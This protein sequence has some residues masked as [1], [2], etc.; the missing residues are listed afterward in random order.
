M[1]RGEQTVRP[2][3]VHRGATRLILKLERAAVLDYVS[4]ADGGKSREFRRAISELSN[5]SEIRA[6][7]RNETI[8]NIIPNV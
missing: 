6:R 7:S 1:Q 4:A 8:S 2:S 3:R 5:L